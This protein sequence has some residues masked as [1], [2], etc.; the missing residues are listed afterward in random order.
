MLISLIE[1]AGVFEAPA[2]EKQNM[3]KEIPRKGWKN[4]YV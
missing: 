4:R 2:K 3:D 1:R